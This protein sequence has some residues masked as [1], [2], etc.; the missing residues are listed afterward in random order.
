MCG[1]FD[2]NNTVIST[3]SSIYD[4]GIEEGTL[5]IADLKNITIYY[6][7]NGAH[8]ALSVDPNENVQLIK[9]MIQQKEADKIEASTFNLTKAGENVD[10]GMTI[11]DAGIVGNTYLVLNFKEIEINVKLDTEIFPVK[12]DPDNKVSTIKDAIKELRGVESSRYKLM[13]GT[14][15]LHDTN[16]INKEKITEG[17]TITADLNQIRLKVDIDDTIV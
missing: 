17:T 14:K 5:L 16:T 8:T 1:T 9:E 2:N 13:R 4:A 15:E 7:R 10:P 6:T 3:S 11:Y 12:V